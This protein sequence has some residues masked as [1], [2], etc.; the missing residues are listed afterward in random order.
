MID[1]EQTHEFYLL[2]DIFSHICM[3]YSEN[4]VA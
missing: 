2:I 4:S 3:Q 1:Y